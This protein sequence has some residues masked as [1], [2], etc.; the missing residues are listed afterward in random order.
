MPE[1]LPALQP[2]RQDK[3]H[4]RAATVA[5]WSLVELPGT[6]DWLWCYAALCGLLTCVWKYTS[7][8]RRRGTQLPSVFYVDV[9]RGP[10]KLQTSNNHL[11]G[12]S[13]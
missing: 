7:D 3:S 2:D 13:F 4:E 9:G 12:A 1:G 6:S 10:S 11:V 5:W 8:I